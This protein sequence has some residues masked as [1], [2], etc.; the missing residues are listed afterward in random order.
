M[1]FMLAPRIFHFRVVMRSHHRLHP[2]HLVHHPPSRLPICP[3][4]ESSARP[5]QVHCRWGPHRQNTMVLVATGSTAQ[6]DAS[7]T[8][9]HLWLWSATWRWVN[10]CKVLSISMSSWIMIYISFTWVQF[11]TGSTYS[12][13]WYLK[14][15]HQFSTFGSVQYWQFA[16]Q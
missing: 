12:E 8:Q 6:E 7:S 15:L 9:F 16:F 3:L 11:N 14:A 2:H 4:R 10:S 5:H 1:K 13:L